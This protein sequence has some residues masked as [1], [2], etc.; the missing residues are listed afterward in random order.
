MEDVLG[1]T[2]AKVQSK[3]AVRIEE[4]NKEEAE[5]YAYYVWG[6]NDKGQI[7]QLNKNNI[8]NPTKFKPIQEDFSVVHADGH[9]TFLK[10]PNGEVLINNMKEGVCSWDLLT[11]RK[12]WNMSALKRSLVYITPE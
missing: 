8:S 12:I 4:N 5:S 10:K 3:M 11:K 9:F 1:I 7:G 2:S 6:R